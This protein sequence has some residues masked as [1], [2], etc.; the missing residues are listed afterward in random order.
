MYVVFFDIDIKL[1]E[2]LQIF[3]LQTK[4]GVKE[5]KFLLLLIS[6]NL[7]LSASIASL[8]LYGLYSAPCA[9]SS[10]FDKKRYNRFHCHIITIV[11][12]TGQSAY[13]KICMRY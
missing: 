4:I 5:K 11:Y 6:F 9:K 1:D 12:S 10:K 7:L 8:G 13:L 2:L 3:P